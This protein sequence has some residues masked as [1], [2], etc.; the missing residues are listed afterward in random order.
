MLY[1]G[2]LET[3]PILIS[4]TG[5]GVREKFVRVARV[6]FIEKFVQAA[7]IEHLMIARLLEAEVGVGKTVQ[8]FRNTVSAACKQYILYNREIAEFKKNQENNK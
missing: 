2:R 1:P 7:F 8:H 4:G 3:L 5:A 6:R